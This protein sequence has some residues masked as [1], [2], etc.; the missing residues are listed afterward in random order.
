MDS[1]TVRLPRAFAPLVRGWRAM[2]GAESFKGAAV[3]RLLAD[4]VARIMS[5]DNE[6]K[7]DLRLLRARA[8]ELARNDSYAKQYLRML[9][10]NVIGR[11]IGMQSTVRLN[12]PNQDGTYDLDEVT[13]NH[14]EDRWRRWSKGPVTVDGKHNLRQLMAI[15]LRAA[16][17]D[18]EC[19]VRKHFGF[20]GNRFGLALQLIDADMLDETFSRPASRGI[21]EIRMGIEVDVYGKPLAYHFSDRTTQAFGVETRPRQRVDAS[22]VLHFY[23]CDRP[24]QT[25]GVTWLHAGMVPL[26]LLGGYEEAEVVAA[27][28]AAQKMGWIVKTNGEPGEGAA[29]K[30]G[31]FEAAP[32]IIEELAEGWQFQSWDPQ[33]PVAAFGMFI[34]TML[35]KIATAFGVSY[36]A[37][38]NDLENVNYSSMR[39]GL[40]IE[41]DQWLTLQLDWV[42]SF[43]QPIYADW[44]NM[45]ILVGELQL[46]SMDHRVYAEA[47]VWKPRGWQWVDPLRDVTALEAEIALGVSSRTRACAERGLVYEDILDE[48]DMEARLAARKGVRVGGKVANAAKISADSKSKSKAADDGAAGS[49]GRGVDQVLDELAGRDAVA[50]GHD[51]LVEMLLSED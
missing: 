14:I 50:G 25:R 51:P 5:A 10:V 2:R 9:V 41:R 3:H 19:F 21:N 27:R 49:S 8:R 33:H 1:R 17:R 43:L 44:L 45:A 26:K 47:A 16:G 18:G 12:I 39:S 40:L 32:G 28:V 36:N 42:E 48:L 38:A 31:N 13:N 4:W 29:T 11:G 7:R 6:I 30:P 35:R 22:E 24:N 34:K 37:L 23:D 20:E 46:P 15:A